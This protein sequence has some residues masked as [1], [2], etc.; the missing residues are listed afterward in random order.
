MQIF[1]QLATAITKMR[2]SLAQKIESLKAQQGRAVIGSWTDDTGATFERRQDG[3][4]TDLSGAPYTPTGT[5]VP[6]GGVGGGGGGSTT[7]SGNI[8]KETGGHLQ[9]I[10]ASLA[11]PLPLPTN[12]AK[13]T[14]GNLDAI[15]AS[16]LATEQSAAAI[17]QA[18]S[19]PIDIRAL[20]KATDSMSVEVA[21]IAAIK[22]DSSATT[23]PVSMADPAPLS[24][25]ASKEAG[26]NLESI[27]TK[28][29]DVAKEA[30]LQSVLN[31]LTALGIPDDASATANVITL[32]SVIKSQQ[33]DGAQKTQITNLPAVQAVNG[34][35]LDAIAAALGTT[36]DPAFSG[37]VNANA[38][39][40]LKAVVGYL[41]G[42][43]NIQASSLPLPADAAK[44]STQQSVLKALQNSASSVWTDDGGAYYIQRQSVDSSTGTVTITY[45]DASGNPATTGAGLRP[46]AS[47][48]S[49][50]LIEFVSYWDAI[51]TTSEYS[52]GEILAQLNV[53]NVSTSPP[54]KV[55]TAWVNVNTGITLSTQPPSTD[56]KAQSNGGN[57][58]GDI[59][60]IDSVLPAG[61]ATEASLQ[62]LLNS[63][64]PL[65]AVGDASWSGLGNATQISIL[66]AVFGVLALI[67]S[68]LTDGTQK[69]LLP[70]N[71][72]KE[73]GGN[74]EAIKT[75]AQATKQ[76]TEAIVG[77]MS[78]LSDNSYSYEVT[79]MTWANVYYVL[80]SA[81]IDY[82]KENI[83]WEFLYSQRTVWD[84]VGG[85]HEEWWE[86]NDYQNISGVN[87]HQLS[88]PHYGDDANLMLIA[89]DIVQKRTIK[90]TLLSDSTV[91]QKRTWTYSLWRPFTLASDT[92]WVAA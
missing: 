27:N 68:E 50:S 31:A 45:T 78:T 11:V 88:G 60:V 23:Q 39:E 43:L 7:I 28:L 61:A 30:T 38:I 63:L 4:F 58:L 85:R 69:I 71:A 8:A 90:R 10:D 91:S 16:T 49:S 53:F 37:G 17:E 35:T 81:G 65:G 36:A 84:S 20:D 56:F 42:T 52:T 44:E 86:E 79:A 66:K 70:D 62:G 26:G 80:N 67:S 34:V 57:Q 25:N 59:K 83:T 18:F 72:S 74:L 64:A 92:G 73:A 32:L 89:E 5:P 6:Y 15:A 29:E 24:P 77:D 21:N 82:R 54:T 55:M 51:A 87:S 14:G 47:G 41:G 1:N 13:E 76:A 19:A 3:T 46:L 12:A 33:A 75:A 9:S 2:E 40:L 22:T 48:G